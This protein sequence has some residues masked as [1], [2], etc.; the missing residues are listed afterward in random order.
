M[1]SSRVVY[2]KFPSGEDVDMKAKHG[3]LTAATLSAFLSLG[4]VAVGHARAGGRGRNLMPM[5]GKKGHKA[6]KKRHRKH[7]KTSQEKPVTKPPAPGAE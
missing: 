6:S 5:S 7:R 3:R 4:G 2:G 1:N